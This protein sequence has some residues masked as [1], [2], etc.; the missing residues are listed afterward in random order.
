[1][2]QAFVQPLDTQ[3]LSGTEGQLVTTSSSLSGSKTPRLLS[4]SFWL[5][6]LG[7]GLGSFCLGV[8]GL[9]V[10]Y[11]GVLGLGVVLILDLKKGVTV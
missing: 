6:C 5:F 7:L 9:E 3:F 4:K 1:M 8:W 11:L 2:C 10:V